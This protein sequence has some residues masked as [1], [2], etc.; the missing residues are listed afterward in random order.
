[1]MREA[2]GQGKVIGVY[3]WVVQTRI[4]WQ[5]DIIFLQVSFQLVRAI[6]DFPKRIINFLPKAW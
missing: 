2:R 4:I 6:V 1:M 3:S 5:G